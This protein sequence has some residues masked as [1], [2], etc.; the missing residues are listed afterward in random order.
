MC[1]I[2]HMENNKEFQEAVKELGL[3]GK[4]LTGE[5]LRQIFN[6]CQE[7]IMLGTNNL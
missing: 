7:N 3:E 5:D 1:D 6:Y 4:Q 2:T